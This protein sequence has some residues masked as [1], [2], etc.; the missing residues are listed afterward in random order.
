[1]RPVERQDERVHRI[2]IKGMAAYPF[3][4]WLVPLLNGFHIDD[5][6]AG[7][8]VIACA[9][10]GGIANFTT[11]TWFC[12]AFHYDAPLALFLYI[13]FGIGFGL[14]VSLKIIVWLADHSPD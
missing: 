14:T 7:P 13:L 2:E 12:K 5:F 10:I 8:F 11:G 4:F 6:P 9:I 3:L 1:M